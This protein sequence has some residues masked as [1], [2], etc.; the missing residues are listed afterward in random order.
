[1]KSKSKEF[2]ASKNNNNLV[3]AAGR[4]VEHSPLPSPEE[5]KLYGEVLS[6]APHR[7]LKI[8][9]NNSQVF[10]SVLTKDNARAFFLKCI[11][12]I[13]GLGVVCW[14]GYLGHEIAA[15]VIGVAALG[16]PLAVAKIFSRR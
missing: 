13:G 11:S 2:V 4:S 15:G 9:E 16:S 6:D 1:M 3:T 5:F 8:A 14:M 10:G 12:V 7:I